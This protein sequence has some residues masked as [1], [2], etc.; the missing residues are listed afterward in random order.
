MNKHF[1]LIPAIIF[2]LSFAGCQIN[3]QEYSID[4]YYQD[5]KKDSLLVDIVTY[6]GYKPRQTDHQTRHN[7]EY[8]EFYIEQSARYNIQYYYISDDSI[9]YYYLIRPARSPRGNQR[10]TGGRFKISGQSEIY[11]FEEIFNTPV[12]PEEELIDKGKIL[13]LEMINSGNIAKYSGNIEYIEWPD[14]RLKYDRLRNEW[15]YDVA[16]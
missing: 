12:L 6:I 4:N 9:H 13:F 3:K 1:Q 14:D 16:D 8:R 2:L 10:G 15:R 5:D 11:E 7:P